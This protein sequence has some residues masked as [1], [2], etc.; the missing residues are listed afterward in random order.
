MLVRSE[1]RRRL[2]LAE[3]G[4]AQAGRREREA[5]DEARED[6][7][8]GGAAASSNSG[9]AIRKRTCGTTSLMNGART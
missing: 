7:L 4:T 2:H 6:L 1:L 3:G 5:D 8:S 9:K